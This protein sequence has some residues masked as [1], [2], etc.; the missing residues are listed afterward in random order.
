[1]VPLLPP[2]NLGYLG[3]EP[4]AGGGGGSIERGRRSIPLTT[5]ESGHCKAQSRVVWPV[6]CSNLRRR[7]RSVRVRA[8]RQF[9]QGGMHT[10]HRVAKLSFYTLLIPPVPPYTPFNLFSP[11]YTPVI[12]PLYP[13]PYTPLIPAEAPNI[14][15]SQR[16]ERKY[17]GL[18][19]G[20][21]VT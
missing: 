21:L 17:P 12:P 6:F 20:P 4:G 13:P 14:P 2:S 19:I 8:K 5:P 11:P 9:C 16:P 3:G 1:M 15:G 10:P 18:P 7:G